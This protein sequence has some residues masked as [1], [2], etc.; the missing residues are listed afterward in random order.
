MMLWYGFSC[1]YYILRNKS[2]VTVSTEID[3][4]RNL[5]I[6]RFSDSVSLPE[7]TK[8][9]EKTLSNPDYKVGMNA[10]WVCDKGTEINVN[11]SDVQLLGDIARQAFDKK[12][13]KYKLALVANDDLAYG[14]LRVYEGWCSN[15]PISINTFRHFDDALTWINGE[16]NHNKL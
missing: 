15:R 13:N 1:E 14:M 5:I 4:V 10:I 16:N 7:L 11:S 2:L 8:T 3:V 6:H 12:E 9:I